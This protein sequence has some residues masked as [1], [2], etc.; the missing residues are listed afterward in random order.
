MWRC[1][2]FIAEAFYRL[3]NSTLENA[4]FSKADNMVIDEFSDMFT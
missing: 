4:I 1:F 2:N 3:R